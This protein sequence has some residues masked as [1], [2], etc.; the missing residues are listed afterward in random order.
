MLFNHADSI[1]VGHNLDESYKVPGLAI[2]NK[3]DVTK[4]EVCSIDIDSTTTLS[5]SKIQWKSEYGSIVYS[6]IG[7]EF[8]EGGMNE[9]GLYIGEM[10]LAETKYIN[11]RTLIKMTVL[12]WMQY[13]LD[14]FENV[15]EVIK[16]L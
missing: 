13:L 12:S 14:N 16:D 6:S 5:E 4:R 11:D 3:R 15:D 9:V 2:V 10:S 1:F 8:I 7:K